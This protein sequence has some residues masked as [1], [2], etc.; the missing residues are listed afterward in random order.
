MHPQKLWTDDDGSAALEF[1]AL[2]TLLLVPLVYLVIA[3]AVIQT[4]TLGAESAARHIARTIASA[5]SSAEVDARTAAVLDASVSEYGIDEES[6]RVDV[7]CSPAVSPCP[8]AGATVIV[9][10]R[11]AVK[12]PL[13]PSFPGLDGLASV[14]V[15]ASAVQ[16]VS[17]FWS[18]G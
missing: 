5:S 18:D 6:A 14:P 15:E 4:Q 8:A 13:A 12:L 11:I 3:L 7:R 1:V 9:T 17:R 2:G 16:K 10:V